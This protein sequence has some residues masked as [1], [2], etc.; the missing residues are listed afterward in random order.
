MKALVSAV[1]ALLLTSSAARAAGPARVP[2]KQVVHTTATPAV[3]AYSPDGGLLVEAEGKAVFV[4]QAATGRIIT[5]L[6]SHEARV[7]CIAFTR[8]GKRFATGDDEGAIFIWDRATLKSVEEQHDLNKWPVLCAAYSPDGKYLATVHGDN[9][10]ALRTADGEVFDGLVG[11]VPYTGVAYSADGHTLAAWGSR[12]EIQLW[13]PAG[14]RRNS[15]YFEPMLNYYNSII[16]HGAAFSADGTSIAACGTYGPPRVWD[17]KTG[18]LL[19]IMPAGQGLVRDLVYSPDGKYLV[20][21]GRTGAAVLRAAADGR[22]LADL[23]GHAGRVRSVA[24][25]PDGKT[26]ATGADDRSLIFWD[27][28]RAPA[29]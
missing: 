11:T 10:I 13:N 23:I 22:I 4:R 21:V 12:P 14:V 18:R 20:T 15:L 24:F 1:L 19:S 6:D 29:P 27:L 7:R 9:A 17:V 2:V 5:R 25:S 8:D 16:T 26:L 28:A 3:A